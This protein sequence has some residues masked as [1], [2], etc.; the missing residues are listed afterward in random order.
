MKTNYPTVWRRI[1]SSKGQMSLPSSWLKHLRIHAGDKLII[2][3]CNDDEIKI[4]PAK[5]AK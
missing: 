1:V 3:V 2:E 4:T 5:F